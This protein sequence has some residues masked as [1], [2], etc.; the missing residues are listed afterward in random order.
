LSSGITGHVPAATPFVAA[1]WLHI[2]TKWA[3]A[4]AIIGGAFAGRMLT[5][6]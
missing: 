6:L 2:L 3:A 4:F 5:L 1:G